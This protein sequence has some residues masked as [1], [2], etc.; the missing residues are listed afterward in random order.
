MTNSRSPDN[1]IWVLLPRHTHSPTGLRRRTTITL[2]PAD[3]VWCCLGNVSTK[4]L[5]LITQHASLS[6]DKWPLLLWSDPHLCW[7]PHLLCSCEQLKCVLPLCLQTHKHCLIVP[8]EVPAMRLS[9]TSRWPAVTPV[10]ERG[11][12]GQLR[13]HLLS[14]VIYWSFAFLNSVLKHLLSV[15][16]YAAT[17]VF[18]KTW[19]VFYCN[20]E[21][22]DCN[23]TQQNLP[24]QWISSWLIE[25]L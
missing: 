10:L 5:P 2:S 15:T 6:S 1:Q 7:H 13:G 3:N 14:P 22:G 18:R 19:S 20:L 8:T 12:L 23:L 9:S 17:H 25:Q 16:L 11:I 21:N 24:S 4:C